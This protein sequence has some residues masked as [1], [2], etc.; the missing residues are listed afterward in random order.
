MNRIDT[1]QTNGN[2]SL[3]Y[4]LASGE[5][6]DQ[7]EMD[8]LLKKNMGNIKVPVFN[9]GLFKSSFKLEILNADSLKKVLSKGLELDRFLEIFGDIV[10]CLENVEKL[11]LRT[12]GLIMDLDGIFILRS[13]GT[14]QMVYIPCVVNEPM[15]NIFSFLIGIIDYARIQGGGENQLKKLRDSIT[16][17]AEIS[18][19]NIMDIIDNLRGRRAPEKPKKQPSDDFGSYLS[20][21]NNIGNRKQETDAHQ[22]SNQDRTTILNKGGK[23]DT[24]AAG[25]DATLFLFGNTMN[26]PHM[27]TGFFESAIPQRSFTVKEDSVIIGRSEKA[28]QSLSYNDAVSSTHAEIIREDQRFYVVDNYSSNGTKI[29]GYE[30]YPGERTELNDGDIVMFAD[31]EFKFHIQ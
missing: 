13:T 14:V 12:S 8:A 6:P 10:K 29:N 16:S 24:T 15:Q 28:G 19:A 26:K 7:K 17:Q 30:I 31:E 21:E 5:K 23:E 22:L 27:S 9:S 20:T 1:I 4:K 3:T 11:Q 25:S 18:Y 2:I